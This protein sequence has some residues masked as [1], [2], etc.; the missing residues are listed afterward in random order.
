M[1]E[2]D[3]S[4]KERVG[5]RKERE[6]D[7]DNNEQRGG[8]R[9]SDSNKRVRDTTAS[10]SSSSHRY[11]D[12]YNYSKNP[13][14]QSRR[15]FQGRVSRNSGIK[16]SNVADHY[17]RKRERSRSR[18]R[19]R[20]RRDDTD[21]V[22]PKRSEAKDEKD[23]YRRGRSR[24][25]SRDRPWRNDE[26]NAEPSGS[27][28]K[29]SNG[30]KDYSYQRERS[31]SRSRD[32]QRRRKVEDAVP[33]RSRSKGTEN[34][35]SR[36]DTSRSRSRDRH[37]RYDSKADESSKGGS[38]NSNGKERYQD[39]NFDRRSDRSRTRSRDRQRIENDWSKRRENDWNGPRNGQGRYRHQKE[40]RRPPPYPNT[41]SE[42]SRDIK[43][44][45]KFTKDNGSPYRYVRYDSAHRHVRDPGPHEFHHSLGDKDNESNTYKSSDVNPPRE[46][47]QNDYLSHSNAKAHH[48]PYHDPYIEPTSSTG[49]LLDDDV[50]KTHIGITQSGVVQDLPSDAMQAAMEASLGLPSGSLKS[51]GSSK[52]SDLGQ[53]FDEEVYEV[54]QVIRARPDEVYEQ[55]AQVG[56]G[57]YGQVF[58]AKADK[59]GI[60]VA[61]KKIRMES[62]KDGFPITAMRE[63]K[64]LQG[65]RHENIVRLHEIL[66]SK[67]SVYMVFEYLQ[68]DLNGILA[69]N[70]IQF[71]PSHLK[72]LAKQLLAGLTY[73]HRHSIL[74][75]D[76]KC[77]NLLLHRDG[78]LKIA[79]FGLARR[80]LKRARSNVDYTNRVVTL[81]YRPPELLF[82][83]TCYNDAIDV[84]GAGCILIELFTR[85]P[86][87]QGNDEIHQVQ[88]LFEMLGPIEKQDWPNVDTLPWYDLVRPEQGDLGQFQNQSIR[89]RLHDLFGNL[90]PSD[91]I[92]VAAAL[93][94]YNPLRRV[95]ASSGLQ[96]R[97]FTRNLPKPEKPR[98][99]LEGVMGEWHEFESRLAKRE[100][101][102]D[103]HHTGS[104]VSATIGRHTGP[105]PPVEGEIGAGHVLAELE[106]SA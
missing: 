43:S 4:S 65:L 15:E 31:N 12:S 93:L 74:H 41:H 38:N 10:S 32:D 39:R 1:E 37:R 35:I 85:K 6:R 66:L 29:E 46:R 94:C 105:L 36:R 99:I 75:R 72:S 70:T 100:F 61:L 42:K 44:P 11:H 20:Q 23:T 59:T 102:T 96:M 60:I 84:W 77:S 34:H 13:G 97:Y 49:R 2:G 51:N 40:T 47:H 90:M 45:S 78:T 33:R 52:A 48:S 87:F 55:V 21:E 24:S 18:S 83:E 101:Q 104:T 58:K 30:R 7:L 71:A 91:A 81:W 22:V 53:C 8:G 89:D 86:I 92:D 3:Y 64:L 9:E 19:D 73:L 79:D 76:L 68:H 27:R 26:K 80:Y 14:W 67:N 69:Q 17:H 95:S 62:E 88:V 98:I 57:T 25:R 103:P 63:I 50:H 5:F 16:E 54:P 82:G 28:F 56:E 106:L